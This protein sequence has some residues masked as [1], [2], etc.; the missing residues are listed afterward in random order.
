MVTNKTVSHTLKNLTE[1]MFFGHDEIFRN[2]NRITRAT[3]I[4]DCTL[5][6]INRTRFLECT[7]YYTYNIVF[8]G[9][10]STFLK[11]GD[12]SVDMNKISAQIRKEEN[13]LKTR[14]KFKIIISRKI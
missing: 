5:I 13:Y 7:V 10:D 12:F 11:Q 8:S 6:Y 3:A 9:D 2:T 14:V 1:G 4:T